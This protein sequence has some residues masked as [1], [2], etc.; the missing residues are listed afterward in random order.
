LLTEAQSLAKLHGRS[1]VF[2]R[3]QKLARYGQPFD[4]R[5]PGEPTVRAAWRYVPSQATR[6]AKKIMP[7]GSAIIIVGRPAS[8]AT[9]NMHGIVITALITGGALIALLV[10]CGNWLIGRGLAPLRR[11]A[12]TADL[13]TRNGDLA[14]RMPDAGGQQETGRLAAAINTML[15]QIQSS[16]SARLR[17][18]QKIRQFAA[19]A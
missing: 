10:V 9:S 5:V 2:D 18:E 15:A 16:F 13:I 19:D 4:L 1:A 8:D 14:A 11:M 3:L 12:H 7:T 17:S 6:S